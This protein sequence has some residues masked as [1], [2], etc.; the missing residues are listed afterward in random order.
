MI[1]PSFKGTLRNEMDEDLYK[2]S[3]WVFQ[4]KIQFNSSPRKTSTR[5]SFFQKT[6][7]A[8]SLPLTSIIFTV[9]RACPSHKHLELILSERFSL[10]E[11]I[12]SEISKCDNLIEIIKKLSIGF[13]RN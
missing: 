8:T 13:C 9:V 5:S 10:T 4:W 6:K 1:H 12:Y 7:S 2:I 11:H 3:N